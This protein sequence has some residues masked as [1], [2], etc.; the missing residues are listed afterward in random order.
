MY[1]VAERATEEL[2]EDAEVTEGAR[3]IHAFSLLQPR[4]GL[5]TSCLTET[6]CGRSSGVEHNLA[7][8]RV[9]RS[10]RLARSSRF[11]KGRLRAPFCFDTSCRAGER[12]LRPVVHRAGG[13]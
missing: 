9:G 2:V 3:V 12:R 11:H 10:N 8:V 5:Y 6:E 7:K 4:A 1:N 13:G